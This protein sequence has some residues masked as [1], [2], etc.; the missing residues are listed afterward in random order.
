MIRIKEERLDATKHQ[1]SQ[2]ICNM[3]KW[4]SDSE[5]EHSSPAV[6][7]LLRAGPGIWEFRQCLTPCL[8]NESLEFQQYL[9]NSLHLPGSSSQHTT[10][11]AL[12]FP[13]YKMWR[14]LY[15][16]PPDRALQLSL[17]R[18]S[19]T[20]KT[21]SS[22]TQQG[23]QQEAQAAL[24]ALCAAHRTLFCHFQCPHGSWQAE[25]QQFQG[26]ALLM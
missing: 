15:S 5:G 22:R 4:S 11:T 26:Q 6:Q 16:H 23:P 2:V 19:S 20:Q 9:N 25:P 7:S 12:S 17:I 21:P 13:C 1:I 3:P 18:K 24:A 10:S 8:S 14:C